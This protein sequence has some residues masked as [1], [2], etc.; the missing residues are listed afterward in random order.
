M[1]YKM[2]S[3]VTLLLR[4]DLGKVQ[5]KMMGVQFT[6]QKVKI[7]AAVLNK[8]PT[9]AF[10]NAFNEVAV[11]KTQDEVAAR[12]EVLHLSSSSASPP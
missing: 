12:N 5:L 4:F 6:A 8:L 7:V 11:R 1:T 2:V 9:I 3:P 10:L